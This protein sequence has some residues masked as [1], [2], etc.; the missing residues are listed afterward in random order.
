MPRRR[1]NTA[2]IV[3]V[4]GA[5]LV[6]LLGTLAVLGFV[7]PGFFL[8]D[9]RRVRA[10]G[11]DRAAATPVLTTF[12]DTIGGG[13]VQ[14]ATAQLCSSAQQGTPADAVGEAVQSGARLRLDGPP[15]EPTTEDR[16]VI[17]YLTGTSTRGTANGRIQATFTEGRWCVSHFSWY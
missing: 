1:G 7:A 6:F 5:G 11:P 9:D 17:G 12:L 8:S 3:A 14:A 13:H 16:Y 15:D 4:V 2:V 10:A